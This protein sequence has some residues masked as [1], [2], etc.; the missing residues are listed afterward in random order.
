MCVF[1]LHLQPNFGSAS[2]LCD[3]VCLRSVV[4]CEVCLSKCL[5]CVLYGMN[6]GVQDLQEARA[7]WCGRD[8]A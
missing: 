3:C 7:G 8:G 2:G 5:K 1:E 4:T 6:V